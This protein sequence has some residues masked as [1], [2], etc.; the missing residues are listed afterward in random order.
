MEGQTDADAG[1]NAHAADG[2][3]RTYANGRMLARYFSLRSDGAARL[4]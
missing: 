1:R 2:R 4:G 3:T